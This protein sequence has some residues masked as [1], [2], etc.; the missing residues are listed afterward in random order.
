MIKICIA[1][2]T[3]LEERIGL[4]EIPNEIVSN[5]MNIM[6][7]VLFSVSLGIV[8]SVMG[9]EGRPLK[10]FFK[11]LEGASMRLISLVIWFVH[12]QLFLILPVFKVFTDW[13]HISNR[14]TNCLDG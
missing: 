1:N 4:Q 14:S 2:V 6:G 12:Y 5:G 11:S 3:F 7:L 9:E 13:H 8:I 10:Q